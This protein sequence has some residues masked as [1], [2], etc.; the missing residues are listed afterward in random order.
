MHFVQ[1]YGLC[2]EQGQSTAANEGGTTH[3]LYHNNLW[4]SP[5][6]KNQGMDQV[7]KGSTVN[8]SDPW[9]GRWRVKSRRNLGFS[10]LV[11]KSWLV[12][13]E[14]NKAY[15]NVP[16]GMS[17]AQGALSHLVWNSYVCSQGGVQTVIWDSI[18]DGRNRKKRKAKF[19]QQIS[20]YPRII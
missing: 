5:D 18:I 4:Q 12:I 6:K 16:W 7:S 3:L 2:W 1:W 8:E 9:K 10:C 17:P 14:S 20:G 19:H 13:T 11:W 15:W